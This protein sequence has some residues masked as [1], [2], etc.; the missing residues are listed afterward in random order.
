MADHQL[1]LSRRDFERELCHRRDRRAFE[2]RGKRRDC[3]DG[4]LRLICRA[5]SVPGVVGSRSREARAILEHAARV[6]P[7]LADVAR[8]VGVDDVQH[9][10]GNV[11]ARAGIARRTLWTGSRPSLEICAC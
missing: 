1:L 6:Q 5:C 9:V 2:A 11:R 10:L 8:L 4:A 7:A 3:A